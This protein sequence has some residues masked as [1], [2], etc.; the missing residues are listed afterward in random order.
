MNSRS[1]IFRANRILS[2]CLP[3]LWL[4]TTASGQA[5][6]RFEG[7]RLVR[8]DVKTPE[9][10]EAVT[11]AGGVILNCHPGLGP[12]DV[13]LA[14]DR[15]GQ[16]ETLGLAMRLLH[17]DV[18]SMI[19]AERAGAVAGGDPF[20]DFFLNYHE[21]GDASQVGTVVWYMNELA[22]RYPTLCTVI[23]VGSTLEGRMI[24]G[25]RVS[26]EAVSNKPAVVYFGCEHAREW[27]TTTIPNYFA[28]YL[29][30]NYGVDSRITEL[31]DQVE[32]FLIPVFN[33]DGYVYTWSNNRLWRKNRRNNGNGTFGVDINRN[34]GEGWGGA[35]SSPSGSNETY[36]GT[37]AFSEPET[38]RLRDFFLAH[39]NVRAQ[40]DIHSY[41]Q[42]ILWPHGYTAT[43][44][45]DQDVYQQIGLGMQSLIYDVYGMDYVPGP[46]YSTIYPASGVSIDW[47]YGQRDILSYSF[48][49]RDTGTF[50][51][52]LP[53]DQI[54]PNNQE[55][56][57]S[58]LLLADSDWVRAP[59]R[60]RFPNGV[61]TQLTA[62]ADTPV[63][64]EIVDQSQTPVAG[65][66]RLLYRFD[67]SAAF[68]EAPLTPLGGERYDA[69][70]P[71]TNCT[72]TPEF[73]FRVGASGG[74]NVVH[75][76]GAPGSGV[77]TAAVT[78]GATPFF[79]EPLN[80]NPVWST[81]G[82]WAFS[83]PGGAGGEHG[84]PD[85]FT[86][87]T[88]SSVYGYNAFGDYP[89]NMPEHHLT[90]GAIDCRGRSGVHLTFW[91]WLGVE[92][93]A[94]DHASVRVSRDGTNWTTVWENATTIA[95][96]AWVFQDF[97]ISAV[98][99]HQPTVYLRW[100]MGPTDGDW[101]FCGWNI[102]DVGLYETMCNG[103]FGDDNG[104]G[105]VDAADAA[106]FAGCYS[107]A[108]QTPPPGC[109]VFL[110]DAD[111][112]VDCA[113]WEAFK[114]A[115]TEGGA[116]PPHVECDTFAAPT[117][118]PNRKNRYVSF[119]PGPSQGQPQA[120]RVTVVDNPLFPATVGMQKWVGAPNAAGVSRLRCSPVFRVWGFDQMDVGDVDV[121]P[122]ATYALEA[123][124]DG[125]S[126]LGP[127]TLL[128]W[129]TWG[130]LVGANVSGVWGPP[131]GV[132]E[133][134]DAVAVLDRFRSASSAPP[135]S[136][137]DLHPAVPD[138]DTQI[139]DV[140]F[141]LDAFRQIPYPFAG[142]SGCP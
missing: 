98:A 142:P 92:Q 26:N 34:W 104:D 138:G 133:I 24:W 106:R 45:P 82:Q 14:P 38:Q 86:A 117:A 95:D 54:I 99:D 75:P 51:F 116:P 12:M 37:A 122:G 88:G 93:P 130:D 42:L 97:D 57:S 56:V 20:T 109:R 61:P 46:V 50:N 81:Q 136:H 35:G 11:D 21:Y 6:R 89:N 2:A 91:R 33:V 3:A 29:L 72:S 65:T 102:D 53:P 134:I 123:T 7:N 80:V 137:T 84:N 119:T 39:P 9:Q 85:P 58:M 15:Q 16:L 87:A 25:L 121:V 30:Q 32:F 132:V 71:G 112:D 70:L 74:G 101:R 90:S 103:L 110:S 66:G 79:S 27:I 115:W 55:L 125:S 140:V 10:L 60:F 68:V 52:L 120:F 96:N 13:V 18:Q 114:T 69:V 76:R 23:N 63:R 64:V 126:F 19:D 77:H 17:E 5:P 118:D 107:G 108:D 100:T 28:N 131:D 8:I 31:V 47:T 40:L 83:P 73:Y 67:P 135:R 22:L 44:P 1:C 62:G 141:V 59:L 36:R 128:T 127:V 105:D 124:L 139:I 49:C 78:T 111:A 43:Y 129:G 41:S 48:E 113:D 94:F 4:V